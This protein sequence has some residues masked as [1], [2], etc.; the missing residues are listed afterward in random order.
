MNKLKIFEDLPNY[1]FHGIKFER[2]KGI[3]ENRFII[4]FKGEEIEI[5]LEIQSNFRIRDEKEVLLNYNDL[6]VDLKRNEMSVRRFRSQIEIEKSY[7]TFE[8]ENVN[9]LLKDR[10][11]KE[12]KFFKYG[13]INLIFENGVVMEIFNDTCIADFIMARLFCKNKESVTEYIYNA[14]N[15]VCNL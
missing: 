7:L 1:N 2:G 13:D 15:W 3:I 12:C 4:I 9:K 10:H 8:L 5:I 11:L 14:Q 6:Y